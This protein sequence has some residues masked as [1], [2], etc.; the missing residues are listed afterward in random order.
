MRHSFQDLFRWIDQ[1]P[2]ERDPNRIRY[3]VRELMGTGRLILLLKLE[4]R[5]QLNEERGRGPFEANASGFFHGWGIAPGDSVNYVL[6]QVEVKHLH[7]VR[8]KM[9]RHL[10]RQKVLDPFRVPG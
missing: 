7:Q 1:I 2:D 3:R 5:R 10:I 9:V 6:R 8:V 4:S